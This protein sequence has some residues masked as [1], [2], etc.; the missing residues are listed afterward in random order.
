MGV[1]VLFLA[2]G[3]SAACDCAFPVHTDFVSFF[4]KLVVGVLSV[5]TFNA[6]RDCH[7]IQMYLMSGNE[8]V[9]SIKECRKSYHTLLS[10]FTS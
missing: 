6:E 3:W 2:L 10:R 9:G 8:I 5:V 7:V 4:F 1:S